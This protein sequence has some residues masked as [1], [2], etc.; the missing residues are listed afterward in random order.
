MAV[1][2]GIKVSDRDDKHVTIA[3]Q[4]ARAF[5]EVVAPGRYLVELFPALAYLPTWFPGAGFKKDA[6]KF[7]KA[8]IALR[9][10]PFR[11]AA[12]AMVR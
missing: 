5:S 8:I 1:V 4:G 3:E 10:I 12:E 9:E 11:A 6:A 2:Y 7:T